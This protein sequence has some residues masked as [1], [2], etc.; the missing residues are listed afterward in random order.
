MPSTYMRTA[1]PRISCA[2]PARLAPAYTS[3]HKHAFVAL[4]ACFGETILALALFRTT[5]WTLI[6]PPIILHTQI[7]RH[8]RSGNRSGKF[9]SICHI[10]CSMQLRKERNGRGAFQAGGE[11]CA[12]H[13][14][15]TVGKALCYWWVLKRSERA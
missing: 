5:S 2:Y 9:Y 10:P 3:C 14:R 12:R 6:H 7:L 8:S 4:A 1:W 11:F 13:A 15:R